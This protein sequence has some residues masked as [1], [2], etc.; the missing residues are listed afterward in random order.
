M[1]IRAKLAGEDAKYLI[2]LADSHRS[3]GEMQLNTGHAAEALAA[4]REALAIR[5]QTAK[6]NPA[7]ITHQDRLAEA[8]A[9]SVMCFFSWASPPRHR[10]T[11]A[12]PLRPRPG[13]SPTTPASPITELRL[14]DTYSGLGVQLWASGRPVEALTACREALQIYVRLFAE[15]Y[16]VS[17]YQTALAK[18]QTMVAVLLSEAGRPAEAVEAHRQAVPILARLARENPTLPHHRVS[19]AVGLNDLAGAFLINGQ[20]AEALPE[21]DKARELLQPLVD[22]DP[23]DPYMTGVLAVVHLNSGDALRALGRPEEARDRF[24]RSVTIL[25]PFV[26]AQPTDTG[27]RT[28][29]GYALRRLGLSLGASREIGAAATAALRVNSLFES[30]PSPR[31][32]VL[33]EMACARSALAGL[34]GKKGSRIPA[35][36]AGPNADRA[37]DL[38]RQAIATGYHDAGAIARD[39]GLTR[40]A[41]GL[42]FSS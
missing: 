31:G 16:A 35:D 3:I 34:A 13:S 38:L 17:S 15:N 19:L 18:A 9:M 32:D 7:I 26:A 27:L 42:T 25:E 5:S 36:Q 24:G 41:L 11:I 14:A 23:A 33:F 28:Y 21:L 40:S 20:P 30:L 8:S 37:I 22:A 4:Y 29:L 2:D 12:R 39:P 6:G 1:V 10:S